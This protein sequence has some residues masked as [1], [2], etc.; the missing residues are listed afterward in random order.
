MHWEDELPE[1]I[2]LKTIRACIQ[3]IRRAIGNQDHVLKGH[4]QNIT[5]S[6]TQYR[7][8]VGKESGETHLLILESLLERQEATGC[9]PRDIDA[10]GIH[11]G[12][13]VLT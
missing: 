9:P 10:G 8:T 2:V 4:M 3:D 11:L 6:E 13:L 7:G 12:K 1:Y 5:L